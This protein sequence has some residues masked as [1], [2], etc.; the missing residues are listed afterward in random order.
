[1]ADRNPKAGQCQGKKK[2]AEQHN[3]S[4]I[5]GKAGERVRFL[6]HC[7]DITSRLARQEIIIGLHQVNIGLAVRPWCANTSEEVGYRVTGWC[8]TFLKND[9]ENN[10]SSLL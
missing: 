7:H 4:A 5:W 8:E 1:V 3:A 10:S 2:D 6:P 9:C